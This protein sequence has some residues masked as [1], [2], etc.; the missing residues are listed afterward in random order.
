MPFPCP[1]GGEVRLRWSANTGGTKYTSGDL[2][3]AGDR[4][5]PPWTDYRGVP[6]LVVTL[7]SGYTELECEN[8][9][10]R[11]MYI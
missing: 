5:S 4:G 6:V 10:W 9:C 8:G 3:A 7:F 1:S 11:V 2:F